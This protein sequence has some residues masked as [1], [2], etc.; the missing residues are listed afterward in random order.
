M[1]PKLRTT[2]LSGVNL[3]EL[4][5]G[6]NSADANLYIKDN[7]LQ[8]ASNMVYK[9]Q[10]FSTRGSFEAGK[11]FLAQTNGDYSGVSR[12]NTRSFILP[13]DAYIFNKRY[14]AVQIVFNALWKD[15]ANTDT[16]N[17][18]IRKEIVV[19]LIDEDG[20]KINTPFDEEVKSTTYPGE[21]FKRDLTTF[22]CYM[23]KKVIE[24][25]LGLFLYIFGRKSEG[26][27][28]K[29]KLYELSSAD[30]K[31]HEI[32]NEQLYVPT[33]LINGKGN[34]YASLPANEATEFASQS[35]WES[36]NLLSRKFKAYFTTDAGYYTKNDGSEVWKGSKSFTI[37]WKVS[38]LPDGTLADDFK[39]TYTDCA[40]NTTE[41]T[42]PKGCATIYLYDNFPTGGDQTINGVRHEK[43]K[44]YASGHLGDE[45]DDLSVPYVRIT[46]KLYSKKATVH[47]YYDIK[48][49]AGSGRNDKLRLPRAIPNNL[50][51]EGCTDD[52]G[53]GAMIGEMSAGVWF[54]GT[55]Q[56]LSGGTRL[57]L[58]GGQNNPN[59]MIWSDVDN[60]LYFPMNNFAFV[61]DQNEKITKLEKQN[62][63]LVIFKERS[64]LYT[65]YV[66]NNM[67]YTT[68]DVLNGSISDIAAITAIFP[69]TNISNKVGCDLPRTVQLCDNHLVWANTN[70]K[71]YVLKTANEYS[72][73]N[74]Y[75]LSYPV[76]PMLEEILK[77]KDNIIEDNVKC[78]P[79]IEKSCFAID[80][81]GKYYLNLFGTVFVM[82]YSDSGFR[83]AS[84]YRE[85]NKVKRSIG[86]NKIDL[87]GISAKKVGYIEHYDGSKK[88]RE[89]MYYPAAFFEGKGLFLVREGITQGFQKKNGS[90]LIT[91]IFK[92]NPEGN[93]ENFKNVTQ[94]KTK[95]YKVEYG[96]I[97]NNVSSSFKTKSFSFGGVSKEKRIEH[98][99]FRAKSK[100]YV[101]L[102]IWA[103]TDKGERFIK[104]IDIL[105]NIEAYHIRC[106]IHG[107]RHI[108]LEFRISGTASIGEIAIKY[109]EL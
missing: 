14:V 29:Y 30:K 77:D 72:E 19:S 57:F 24:N 11:P 88:N 109:K 108:A 54:G 9:E 31:F 27:A 20:E 93:E 48:A 100:S 15:I 69:I 16:T 101:G 82:N 40:G 97:E 79:F 107:I 87:K 73:N 51:F 5:G 106:F 74:I 17:F 99:K 28:F 83:Y 42:I 91:Q 36:G 33:M 13:I 10:E 92:Y 64:V 62:S 78:G 12:I 55:G 59:K 53:R 65:S 2:G 85:G 70:G 56:G 7:Q 80:Y 71:V 105:P 50:C 95:P 4:S 22:F 63:M 3:P 43:G 8:S 81:D 61:G 47:F 98:I 103:H 58:Y 102:E 52:N 89:M 37:P 84:S 86:W 26:E 104:K 18:F 94:I 49:G 23:G 38:K 90:N 41:I 46:I 67:G 96:E 44:F 32:E 68:D 6:I 35:T 76:A 39:I 75:E 1:L 66:D 25:G 34:S 21:L 45:D 60:P